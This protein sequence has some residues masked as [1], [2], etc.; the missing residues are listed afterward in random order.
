MN[1]EV[2]VV[3]DGSTDGTAGLVESLEATPLRL[4][5]LRNERNRGKGFSVRR[6]MLEAQGEFLLMSDADFSTPIQEVEKLLPWFERGFDVVIGSRRM[7]ESL[8][9][10]AQPLYRRVMDRVFRAYRRRIMLPEIRDT[11][12]GFKCFRREAGRRI[13]ENVTTDGFAFDCEALGLAVKMG[14]RIQEIGVIWC[15][16]PDTRVRWWN[17]SFRMAYGLL[18]IRKRLKKLT[19]TS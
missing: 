14:F 11:Q 8:L 9:R 1:I 13:F 4:R 16:D 18:K 12:C 7:P 2:I 15:N 19:S 3:D 6:G 17:D 5:V 10:P